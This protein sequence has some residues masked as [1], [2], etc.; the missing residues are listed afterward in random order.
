MKYYIK[1]PNGDTG[2]VETNVSINDLYRLY[3]ADTVISETPFPP[4]AEAPVEA[5]PVAAEKKPRAKTK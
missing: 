2:V 4:K 3:P 5:E 1:E